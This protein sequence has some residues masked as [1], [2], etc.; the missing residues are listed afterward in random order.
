MLD[1]RNLEQI[2]SDQQEDLENAK[3]KY[4]YVDFDDERL[5]NVKAEDLKTS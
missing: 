5:A 2:L 1:K 4:A 3:V